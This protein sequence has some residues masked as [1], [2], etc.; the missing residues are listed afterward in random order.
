MKKYQHA[1][2]IEG[3]ALIKLYMVCMLLAYHI[4]SVIRWGFLSENIPQNL[5][6][7]GVFWKRK[8]GTG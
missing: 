7:R 5:D 1:K 8:E 4:F 2:F 3:C 6:F